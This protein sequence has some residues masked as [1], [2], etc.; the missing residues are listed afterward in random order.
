MATFDYIQQYNFTCFYIVLKRLNIKIGK[1]EIRKIAILRVG[2]KTWFSLQPIIH[3][4]FLARRLLQLI[5][6]HP[7]RDIRVRKM[8]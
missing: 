5:A 4:V 8:L 1:L 3:N 7:P 6:D 2:N